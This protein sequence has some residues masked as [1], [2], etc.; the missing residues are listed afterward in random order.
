MVSLLV[1]SLTFREGTKHR[2]QISGGL[3]SYLKFRIHPTVFVVVLGGRSESVYC[4]VSYCTVL[5]VRT[6]IC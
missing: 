3:E 6:I 2:Q 5:F 4:I 1:T